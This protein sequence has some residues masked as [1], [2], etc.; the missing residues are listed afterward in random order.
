MLVRFW[1]GQAPLGGFDERLQPVFRSHVRPQ[2]LDLS[3]LETQKRQ[4]W[5]EVAYQVDREHCLDFMVVHKKVPYSPVQEIDLIVYLTDCVCFVCLQ[6]VNFKQVLTLCIHCLC[7]SSNKFVITFAT[8]IT[9]G[10]F[11]NRFWSNH[12]HEKVPESD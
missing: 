6:L 9:N 5:V 7:C 1:Q 11:E 8:F 3:N 10:C 12:N 4:I 2:Y